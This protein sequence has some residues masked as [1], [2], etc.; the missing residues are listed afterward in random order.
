MGQ[1]ESI[2]EAKEIP[3]TERESLIIGRRGQ[4]LFKE[5]V[6]RI[7]RPKNHRQYQ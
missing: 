2:E 4:G 1:Y 5:R 3:E 7:E 6:M